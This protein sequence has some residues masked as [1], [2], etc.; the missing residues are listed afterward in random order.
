M[1]TLLAAPISRHTELTRTGGVLLVSCYE[2]GH[3]P[4]NLASP[5][6]HLRAA[7][8]DPVAIDASIEALDPATVTDARLAAISV[9]M[10]TALRLGT[11]IA[12]QIRALNPDVHICFYGLY[13]TL[14]ARFLLDDCGDSVIGGEYETA[15]TGL[16]T[17]FASDEDPRRV[18]GVGFKDRQAAPVLTRLD[19]VAPARDRLPELRLYAGLERNGLI[20]RAA[21][22][23]A[24]R[25]CHHTCGHCPIT[26]IYGGRFFAIPREIVRTDARNQVLAG[27]RH[28]T[29]GDPDFFNGPQHG[30]RIMRALRAEFPFLTFDATIKIEHLLEHR[31][32]VPEL[33]E[34]GCAFVVSAVE[35]VSDLVLSKL[36]KGHTRDNIDTALEIL[37]A[38]GIPMRP[39]LLPFTPWS[40][41][42]DYQELLQFFAERDLVEHVD[43]V[44]FSIRLLV[45]PGSA[46][47]A[48]PSS[49]EWARELDE[50]A[51]SYRWQ[52]TDPT[53]D[54]LQKQVASIVE[55]AA[56]DQ[57]PARFTFGKIWSVAYSVA[58]MQAPSLPVPK[59]RRP[60]PPRLTESW[61][62]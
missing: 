14:N 11:R 38:S 25:G 23:E 56:A 30:L 36:S 18:P 1:T 50:E 46:L 4:L 3:Q 19:Y 35:S 41:I 37:D 51:F 5:L 39:S 24:T 26:P 61:F 16:A 21:Y 60:V 62:C 2:L 8:F 34:L 59:S 29:F 27:A 54:R 47:L 58:G 42:D 28:I 52:S 43:P 44:H 49:V 9:P 13:A 33:A 15:L 57:E 12:R 20:V 17:A 32:L 10:H 7:G 53:L 6:A 45:P 55:N 31:H 48:D 22:V 40:T